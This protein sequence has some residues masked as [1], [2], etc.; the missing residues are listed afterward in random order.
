MKRRSTRI[1]RSTENSRNDFKKKWK[2]A[3]SEY[4]TSEKWR[5]CVTL[6]SRVFKKRLKLHANLIKVESSL[7][8]QMRTNRI[9][10]TKYLFHRRMLTVSFSTCTCEWFKQLMKHVVL[11]CLEYNHTRKIMLFVVETHDFRQ[12]L[13]VLRILKII[14]RW[15]M[16]TNLL[17]QFSLARECFEWFRSIVW[18]KRVHTTSSRKHTI[19]SNSRR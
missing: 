5:I 4:Q 3:W 12:L 9:S 13:E 2:K 7:V 8:T 17:T 18:A 6:S 14:T 1:R 16:N 19:S 11:F 15:L 10:L